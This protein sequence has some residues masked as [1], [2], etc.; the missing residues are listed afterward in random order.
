MDIARTTPLNRILISSV[1]LPDVITGAT[2]LVIV[3]NTTVSIGIT[4]YMKDNYIS[5]CGVITDMKIRQ[6]IALIL[7]ILCLQGVS[8][9][10]AEG[11]DVPAFGNVSG[12]YTFTSGSDNVNVLVNVP[13]TTESVAFPVDIFYFFAILGSISLFIGVICTAK[14]DSV[15][16]IAILSCG[17]IAMGSF[18]IAAFMSPY[19]AIQTINQDITIGTPNNIYI[20]LINTYIFSPWVGVAMGGAGVAGFLMALLGGLSFIGWFHRKGIRDASRG[21]YIESDVEDDEPVKGKYSP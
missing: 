14:S 19:V 16:S 4:N 13:L 21:K 8:A 17:L 1:G 15:P 11:Q 9:E 7:M 18:F 6:I 10:V 5:I 20:T 2:P 12:N 3:G